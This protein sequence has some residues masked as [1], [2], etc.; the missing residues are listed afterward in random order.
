M[1]RVDTS[2]VKMNELNINKKDLAKSFPEFINIKN[3][4]VYGE[5]W[6]KGSM[7]NNLRSLITVTTLVSLDALD[8]EE[9]LNAALHIGVT[10]SE[11]QE[12]FHQIAPYIGIAKSEKG[13][14]VLE[15]VFTH[16]Q[17]Q[18]PILNSN[19]KE[20]NRLEK[21]IEVQKVIFGEM[22]D[23]MRVNTPRDLKFMQDYLSAYCFGDTYTRDG[24][25][26]QTR[27]LLTFV[28]LIS[29]GGCD[30]QVKAHVGGNIAIGNDRSILLD[31]VNQCLPYIG[32][33]RALNAIS[34]INELTK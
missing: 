27:E 21:G 34:V 13:L 29:M 7:E 6:N 22:I 23:T 17:I 10:P 24:L 14:A 16:K 31:T 9:Q 1:N 19:V 28:S 4:F 11:L 5:V 8:L 18:L 20:E 33:P 2:K 3:K 25:D 30:P 15:K 26:L 12:V 32:F